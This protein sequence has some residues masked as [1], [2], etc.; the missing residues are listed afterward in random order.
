MSAEKRCG[1]LENP[2]PANLWLIDNDSEWTLSIQGRGFINENSMENM[3]S[4][5]QKEFVRTNGNY[6]FS[7]VCL[8]VKTNKEKSEILEVYSGEQLLLKQCLEDPNI[9]GK[10]PLR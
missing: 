5:D 8:N 7:C 10:I 6:G 4:I 9:Y 2:T 3:P 1:W